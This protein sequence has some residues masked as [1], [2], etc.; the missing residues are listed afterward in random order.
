[1]Q[2][3]GQN[4]RDGRLAGRRR[5]KSNSGRSQDAVCT[6][7]SFVAWWCARSDLLLSQLA[8]Q[9]QQYDPWLHPREASLLVET[10]RGGIVLGAKYKTYFQGKTGMGL[11][12]RKG[13]PSSAPPPSLTLRHSALLDLSSEEQQTSMI[14]IL[15]LWIL[16]DDLLHITAAYCRH[17][18][19]HL[20]H[21]TE[22]VQFTKNGPLDTHLRSCQH[23]VKYNLG[24]PHLGK[25]FPHS[26]TFLEWE[27]LLI[28]NL[29]CSHLSI[30]INTGIR[31]L[32][33]SSVFYHNCTLVRWYLVSEALDFCGSLSG[34]WV[35]GISTPV[36]P[37]PAQDGSSAT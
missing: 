12:A 13:L 17:S 29:A 19:P 24:W 31:L 32:A 1:M 21:P 2:N 33:T 9:E 6:P 20:V 15:E 5:E 14:P 3:E 36:G 16:A 35:D 11:K 22:P 34:A 8:T 7:R 4:Q 23:K 27:H 28:I 18:I 10:D 26:P 37:V 25:Q 30:A